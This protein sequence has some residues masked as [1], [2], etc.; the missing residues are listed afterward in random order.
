MLFAKIEK[1]KIKN[2][3]IINFFN[4]ALR[5]FILIYKFLVYFLSIRYD[6]LFPFFKSMQKAVCFMLFYL[7]II[8]SYYLFLVFC[9]YYYFVYIIIYFFCFVFKFNYYFIYIITLFLLLSLVLGV[10]YIFP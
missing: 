9:F 7:I 1:K 6:F 5:F 2:K 8:Y 4:E 10:K 3:T